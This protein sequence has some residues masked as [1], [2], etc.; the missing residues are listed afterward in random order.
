MVIILNDNEM[1]IAPNV[2]GF[3]Q[4]LSRL[5]TKEGYLGLKQRYRKA[6]SKSELGR[7]VYRITRRMKEWLKKVLLQP[8]IFENMGLAYLGPVDGH[9]LQGLISLLRLAKEMDRPVLIH[10]HTQ[11]GRGYAPAEQSPSRFHGVG[12]FD[13]VTGES[14]SAKCPSFSDAFGQTMLELAEEDSRVCAITAAMPEG[15][16]L[17]GFME[18]YPRRTFDVGIAEE[19]AVSMAGGLA[20]QGMVPVVALYSTFLQRSFDQIMQDIAMLKLHVVLAVDRAGLVGEDGETHHGIYDTGFLRLVPG[21]T[22]LCPASRRELQEILRWAVRDFDGPVAIRYP[23]GGDGIF[24]DSVW[25]P[26]SSVAIHRRGKDCAII[27]YGTLVN[28]AMAAADLLQKQGVYASVIRLTR[29]S[30]QAAEEL[31][32]AVADIPYVLIAEEASS[33]AA[34]VHSISTQL[35]GKHIQSV[36]LGSAY[37]PHGDVASLY[38][39]YGL[40]AQSIANQ[41]LEVTQVEK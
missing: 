35:P 16:G 25:N 20:K 39:L 24:T 8:T 31:A 36:N 5:R 30:S 18:M 4:H 22:V 10:V 9:D 3:A 1:S 41:I 34:L 28:N 17:K 14:R 6:L 40:D 23:R 37:V 38:R 33:D 29:I 11:K 2:G 7:G 15:T 26:Q 13:P 12:K 32:D 27:T 21:M 19:H